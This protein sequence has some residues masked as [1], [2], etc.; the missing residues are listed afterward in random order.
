MLDKN[1]KV[2]KSSKPSLYDEYT[3]IASAA[4]NCN[5]IQTVAC[6]SVVQEGR[7]Q[8]IFATNYK[9]DVK[10]NQQKDDNI[11]K[12]EL[13]DGNSKNKTTTIVKTEEI[14]L[15]TES[16]NTSVKENE[17]SGFPP[18]NNKK[19]KAVGGQ[20]SYGQKKIPEKREQ[21][22]LYPEDVQKIVDALRS[23]FPYLKNWD[24]LF[25][26]P[27]RPALNS[28]VGVGHPHAEM[29]ILSYSKEKKLISKENNIIPA[30]ERLFV[31]T[32]KLVCT[33]CQAKL[34]TYAHQISY[35]NSPG[36]NN[37]TS[38]WT[39]PKFIRTKVAFRVRSGMFNLPHNL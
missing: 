4:I 2:K 35:T 30:E 6:T 12:T 21:F 9:K 13:I 36:S 18:K 22:G 20:N 7:R 25:L 31:G 8:L 3:D 28:L 34:D 14:N 17:P 15:Y 19:K 29:Q 16:N 38:N 37:T 33:R 27:L 24:L 39:K 26:K 10:T 11:K 32:S 23:K 5:Q 1:F